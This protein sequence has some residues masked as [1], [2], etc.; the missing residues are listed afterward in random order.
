MKNVALSW[1]SGGITSAVA[2]YWAVKTFK[3]VEVVFLDTKNN[4][5]PDTYR[6]LK[7][8]ER[9]YKQKIITISNDKYNNIQDVWR[10]YKSLNTA[11]GAI[12]S[13]ELKRAMR[14]KY[15]DLDKHYCQVFGF[16]YL[17]SQMKRHNN[18][19]RNYPEIN[20]VSPLI[21]LKIN[22]EDSR[23]FIQDKGIKIPEP[24]LLGYENN[25]CYKTGCVQGGCGYWGM[26]K[27]REPE[28]FNAMADLEHELTEAKGQ[29][30]T[31]CKDQSGKEH[32]LI[33]LKH[34]PNYPNV[35]DISTIKGRQPE[36]LMECFGFCNTLK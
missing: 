22:K 7:D 24:Y 10:K 21:D 9:L 30:V 26:I 33:F 11:H 16:E 15:Q 25:N 1:F 3:K 14:E 31:I 32:K 4:E 35:K 8:C 36:P 34:N 23:R 27:K 2:C 28:K 12:C 17:K 5:H 19:R 20:V 6:F 29:P 13:T 18:M